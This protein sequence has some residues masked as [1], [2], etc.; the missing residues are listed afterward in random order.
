MARKHAAF[1]VTPRMVEAALAV[2][3]ESERHVS[4]ED[5]QA[6]RQVLRVLSAAFQAMAEIPNAL[7]PEEWANPLREVLGAADVELLSEKDRHRNAAICLE[8]HPGGFTQDDVQLLVALARPG[9]PTIG[10]GGRY[11]RCANLAARLAAIVRPTRPM[12]YRPHREFLADAMREAVDVDGLLGL[13]AHL[14]AT[15]PPFNTITVEPYAGKDHRIGWG[16]THIVLLDGL[17]V[18]FCEMPPPG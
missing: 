12:R 17:P 7:T 18:G 8:G 9:Q 13:E 3:D 10:P 15:E 1:Q 4:Q 2:L 11:P 14:R 6:R 16:N 5:G